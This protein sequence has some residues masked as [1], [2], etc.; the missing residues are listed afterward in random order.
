MDL[1]THTIS[2]YLYS[3]AWS[4]WKI[5]PDAL[6]DCL[7]PRFLQKIQSNSTRM[8]SEVMKQHY[9]DMMSLLEN[10]WPLVIRS[11]FSEGFI[12]LNNIISRTGYMCM[13]HSHSTGQ[14]R[15]AS[16][17]IYKRDFT[18]IEAILNTNSICFNGEKKSKYG[19]ILFHCHSALQT[20]LVNV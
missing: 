11:F 4:Q 16:N 2:V 15:G 18:Y 5:N 7:S 10:I 19:W 12:A 3:H 14:R 1:S 17:Y 8:L 20:V 9:L 6:M 13:I